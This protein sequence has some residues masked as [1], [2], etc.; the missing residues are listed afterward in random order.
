MSVNLS[1]CLIVYVV[2]G[3]L[4]VEFVKFESMLVEFV[5]NMYVEPDVSL[6]HCIVIFTVKF[7]RFL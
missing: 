7:T 5:G 2:G 6:V 3:G 1:S 4:I